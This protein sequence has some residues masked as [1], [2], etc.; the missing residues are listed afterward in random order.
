MPVM[1]MWVLALLSLTVLIEPVLQDEELH[2][3]GVALA[4]QEVDQYKTFLYVASLFMQTHP[5][6][7][8]F[9]WQDMRAQTPV[10]MA[11]LVA[12]YP[13]S[14]VVVVQD[15][16]AWS[17]CTPMSGES[18][19]MVLQWA[20]PAGLAV[21]RAESNRYVVLGQDLNLYKACP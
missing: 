7:G 15:G 13:P 19:G 12:P 3:A 17:T 10:P 9:H 21:T 2:P 6:V 1:L 11:L 20:T 5:G 18:I 16:G 4:S 8:T 14:W